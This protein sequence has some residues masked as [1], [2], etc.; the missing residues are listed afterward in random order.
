MVAAGAQILGG[1]FAVFGHV[2]AEFRDPMRRFLER[3]KGPGGG[4]RRVG[5]KESHRNIEGPTIAII[6]VQNPHGLTTPHDDRRPEF[7]PHGPR[8]RANFGVGVRQRPPEHR[9]GVLR[10]HLDQRRRRRLARLVFFGAE[11][12]QKGVG[13]LHQHQE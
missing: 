2:A 7:L 8:P 12:A 5:I 13:V 3:Q 6:A 1:G 4:D 9:F 11:P 10:P